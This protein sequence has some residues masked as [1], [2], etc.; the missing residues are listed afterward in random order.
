MEN[1][2]ATNQGPSKGTGLVQGPKLDMGSMMVICFFFSGYPMMV[3]GFQTEEADF[4]HECFRM[5]QWFI[6]HIYIYIGQKVGGT[7]SSETAVE[8]L[9]ALGGG[10]S[11]GDVRPRT[12]PDR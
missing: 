11:T 1:T 12:I 2:S 7:H 10:S 9:S 5:I 4:V 6:P 8:I 3:Q